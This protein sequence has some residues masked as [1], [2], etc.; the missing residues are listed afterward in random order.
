MTYISRDKCLTDEYDVIISLFQIFAFT[1]MMFVVISIVVFVMGTHHLF[2]VDRVTGESLPAMEDS[3]SYPCCEQRKKNTTQR[4]EPHKALEVIDYFCVSFFTIEILLRF[5]FCPMKLEFWKSFLNIIDLL[6]LI[7][8]IGTI[9]L[10]SVND[11]STF[12]GV[13]KAFI[14]LRVSRVLR[15]FK[16][17]KHYAAFKILVYT[18][19]VSAKELLL[20][21]VFLM[22]GVLVFASV[23]HSAESENFNNIPI[24]IWWALVT[25]TTVGYGDKA[26]NS[27]TGYGIGSLCVICGVLVIAFTVPIVV[28][29]FSLYYSHAQTRIKMPL[30]KRKQ[31]ILR[32]K[33]KQKSV[34]AASADSTTTLTSRT[35]PDN[36]ENFAGVQ[37]MVSPRERKEINGPAK[38][39]SRPRGKDH[40][41]LRN[42]LNTPQLTTR[43]GGKIQ[44]S[45]HG[46]ENQE[47]VPAIEVPAEAETF[48]LNVETARQ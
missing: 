42:N 20:M 12:S 1:S 14:I 43:Q 36:C 3:N 10:N 37:E 28:N 11:N 8:H 22:S 5:I 24:G 44:R 23:I 9:I 34:D 48:E 40:T 45:R 39:S 35:T 15:I 38:E 25:M 7:P 26:P 46:E 6:C 17:M 31:K 13:L 30:D 29:N 16:L 4:G 41:Y 32:R 33:M 21:V 19:K 2:M 27:Y 47:K 18:I